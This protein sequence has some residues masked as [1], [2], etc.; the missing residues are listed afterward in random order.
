MGGIFAILLDFLIYFMPSF[1]QE[2][3]LSP[4]AFLGIFRQADSLEF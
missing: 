3:V 2:S 1:T 4:P